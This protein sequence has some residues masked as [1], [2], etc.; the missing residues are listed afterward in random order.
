MARAVGERV[1][2]CKSKGGVASV[3]KGEDLVG[4]LEAERERR[5]VLY[6]D[7][8]SLAVGG[9]EAAEM[10]WDL[11]LCCCCCCC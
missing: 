4:E 2:L 3:L 5:G 9:G 8:S 7:S 6:T 11:L 1:E 10:V